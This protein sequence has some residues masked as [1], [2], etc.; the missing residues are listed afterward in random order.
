MPNDIDRMAP[1]EAAQPASVTAPRAGPSCSPAATALY[2]LALAGGLTLHAVNMYI[3]TTV[4]PTVVVDIGGSLSPDPAWMA[5]GLASVVG[6]IAAADAQAKAR[7]LSRRSFSIAT[8]LGALYL[9]IALLMLSMQP[10]IYVPYLL[11][12]LRG[13]SPLWAGYLA[14][15]MAI[16]WTVAS[17]LSSR[18]QE[19]GGD[20]LVASGPILAL[21]GLVL[22]V[23]FLPI[24]GTF[25]EDRRQAVPPAVLG[26]GVDR[27]SFV[28]GHIFR[29]ATMVSGGTSLVTTVPA[30]MT[31]RAPMVTPP[32]IV[33]WVPIQTPSSIVIGRWVC[34]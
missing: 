22:P 19:G 28:L 18:W 14:A 17:F 9:A 27:F 7:L 32:S 33:A 4:M 25:E 24:H 10:E 26:R 1:A 2:A 21:A 31:D 23:V 5:M 3:A 15:L 6:L 8:P 12:H 16:G 29:P 13:Q 20:R 11:Q 30:P 34:G